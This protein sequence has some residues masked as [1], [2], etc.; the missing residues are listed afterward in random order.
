MLKPQ[1]RAL[2]LPVQIKDDIGVVLFPADS[3][4]LTALRAHLDVDE[5]LYL[6]LKRELVDVLRAARLG[7]LHVRAV[8]IFLFYK[9]LEPAQ[10]AVNRRLDA[11]HPRERVGELV[12]NLGVLRVCVVD[13]LQDDV[14]RGAHL[15]DCFLVAEVVVEVRAA[16]EGDLLVEPQL[17]LAR[18]EKGGALRL[19]K[20]GYP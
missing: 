10:P 12:D 4:L 5:E 1:S 14:G 8:G 7:V 9:L 3:V 19:K 17:Q 6:L 15:E 20:I 16:D 11:V 13:V 18:A 2:N